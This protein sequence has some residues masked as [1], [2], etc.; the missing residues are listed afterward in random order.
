MRRAVIIIITITSSRRI[1]RRRSTMPGSW[2][3]QG[4]RL[5]LRR[6]FRNVLKT[7]CKGSASVNEH[8]LFFFTYF[9]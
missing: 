6:I 5:L 1:G 9:E 3:D 2:K 4:A 8:M 7:R